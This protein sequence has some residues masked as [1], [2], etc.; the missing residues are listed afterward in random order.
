ML[1]RHAHGFSCRT[2]RSETF[3]GVVGSLIRPAVVVADRAG[4]YDFEIDHLRLEQLEITVLRYGDPV[5]VDLTELAPHAGRGLVLQLVVAGASESRLG[6]APGIV[7]SCSRGHLVG[8]DVPMRVRCERHCRHFLVRFERS[9]LE[10]MS[11]SF[12]QPLQL[13]DPQLPLSLATPAGRALRRYV[14]Y[15]LSELH[16]PGPLRT[17]GPFVQATRQTLLALMLDA[18]V[19]SPATGAA[20]PVEATPHCVRRAQEF[21]AAYLAED[22]GLGDI[23]ANAGV[24]RRTLYRSFEKARGTTPL[25]FLRDQRLERV[26]AELLRADPAVVG[27]TDIALR[28]GFTHLSDFAARYRARFGCLPSDTLRSTRGR[29]PSSGR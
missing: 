27:V 25:G 19:E 20:Y 23:V 22:I 8:N 15:L 2:T 9:V 1:R 3:Q 6:T 21:I 28:W 26:H 29:G 18:F 17:P 5:E 11:Q 10:Q 12:D 16:Q 13:P 4:S 14:R 7:L 24:S